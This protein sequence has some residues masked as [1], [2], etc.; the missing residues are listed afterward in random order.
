[1][2]LLRIIAGATILFLAFVAVAASG[3]AETPPAPA[4]ARF[5]LGRIPVF[6]VPNRGQADSAVRFLGRGPGGTPY[7]HYYR[8]APFPSWIRRGGRLIRQTGGAYL[9][10]TSHFGNR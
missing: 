2:A 9:D 7:S 1:M 5:A 6:F 10:R 3:A 8:R 4:D